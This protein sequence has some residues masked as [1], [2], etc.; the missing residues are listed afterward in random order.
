[1]N[2]DQWKTTPPR[3][4]RTVETRTIRIEMDIPADVDAS[5]VL[6]DM[7]AYACDV[8]EEHA[9]NVDDWDPRDPDQ[10]D[11]E[12][13]SRDDVENAVSVEVVS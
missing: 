12:T 13:F 11:L 5:R 7:Q 6:E 1:M 4:P 3:E 9:T 2:Y 8:T 10:R